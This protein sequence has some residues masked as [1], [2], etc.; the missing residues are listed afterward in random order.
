VGQL[1][2]GYWEYNLRSA[3]NKTG[4]EKKI[5]YENTYILK[6]I[7]NVVT[8]G[9]EAL[10][11]LGNK[12]LY[13]CVQ[14]ICR[15]WIQPRSDTFHQLLI[16]VEALWSQPILQ[17]GKEVTVVGARS[18]LDGSQTTPSWNDPAVLKCGEMYADTHCHGEALY[19]MSAFHAFCSEWPYAVILVFRITLTRLL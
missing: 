13:A 16:I 18:G 3:V 6:T 7:L 9:I 11:V 19:R 10:V 1:Q 4:N 15:S 12:F 8:A 14:E 2:E 5:L 17:V